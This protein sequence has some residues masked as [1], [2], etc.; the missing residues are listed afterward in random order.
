MKFN[1]A[2]KCQLRVFLV[3]NIAV[4]NI[5]KSENF[6]KSMMSKIVNFNKKFTIRRKIPLEAL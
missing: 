1:D 3:T 4:Y 6:I 5:Q 2:N